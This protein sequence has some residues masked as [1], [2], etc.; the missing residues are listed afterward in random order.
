MREVI[1]I[2]VASLAT[3]LLIG[4]AF[5]PEPCPEATIKPS[6]ETILILQAVESDEFLQ[7]YILSPTC[8]ERTRRAIEEFDKKYP[9]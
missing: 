8:R 7:A 6:A 1:L 5:T 4:Y 3:F 2:A 9:R